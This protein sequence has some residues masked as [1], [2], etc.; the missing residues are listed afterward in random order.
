MIGNSAG[1]TDE[2]KLSDWTK[3][4]CLLCMRQFPSKEKL[5]KHNQIS[6][7]HKQNLDKWRRSCGGGGGSGPSGSAESAANRANSQVNSMVD[8]HD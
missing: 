3:M 1:V 7:L 5:I 8:S 4:A 6:D 2:A